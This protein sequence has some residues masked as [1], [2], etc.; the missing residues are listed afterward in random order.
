MARPGRARSLA[1]FD[2]ARAR[3]DFLGL[4]AIF[5]AIWD[6]LKWLAG[7]VADLAIF[8]AHAAIQT[9]H[10]IWNVL[11]L[12]GRYAA[13]FA[14]WVKDRFEQLWNLKLK[15]LIQ[16]LY[17][18][19]QKI[20][21][22]LREHFGWLL[23][24]V[25]RVAQ[26]L[27]TVW[28]KIIAPILNAIGWIRAILQLLAKLGVKWAADLDRWLA[29]LELRIYNAFHWLQS[30]VNRALLIL[31]AIIGPNGLIRGLLLLASLDPIVGAVVRLLVRYGTAPYEDHD[32]EELGRRQPT[33]YPHQ[34]FAR[35]DSPEV[36]TSP[37]ANEA[38]NYAITLLEGSGER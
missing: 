17:R 34:T 12:L 7:K 21:T 35:I 22:F 33:E 6:G 13:K 15:P 19:L 32:R 9:A 30:W 28:T 18:F 29:Q 25:K 36:L 14:V 23:N 8:L 10:Q 3:A 11:K 2:H 1:V 37:R 27:Q 16:A 5:S 4:G 31:D 24:A 38:L 26:F 20:Q